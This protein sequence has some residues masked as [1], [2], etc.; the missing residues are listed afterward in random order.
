MVR[1]L[2]KLPVIGEDEVLYHYTKLNGIQGIILERC[3]KS[4]FLN[5]TNF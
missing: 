3:M 5:D 1:K 4:S 2:V